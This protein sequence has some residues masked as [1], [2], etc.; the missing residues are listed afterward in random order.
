MST[1][2]FLETVITF[3]GARKSTVELARRLQDSGYDVLLYDAYGTCQPFLD[4]CKDNSLRVRILYPSRDSH[5]IST[6]N[7]IKQFINRASFLFNSI[8]INK[9]LRHYLLSDKPRYVIVNNSKVLSFLFRKPNEIKVMLFARGWF[10]GKQIRTIDRLLYKLFVDRYVCVS[11][12]TRQAIYG[13]GLA[14]LED[15]Y[16]VH[17]AIETSSVDK[18]KNEN[19]KHN[20]FKILISGGFLP[21][22]GLHL[23]IDIALRLLEEQFNFQIIITGIIYK[24]EVSKTYYE[25]IKK[26][27]EINDL[28]GYINLVIDHNDVKEYFEWCDILVHPS[29]TEGLP[30]VVMEAMSMKKP[31][32]ANAV[33]GVTDYILDGFTGFLTNYNNVE[34]YVDIIKRLSSDPALYDEISNRAFDLIKTS[35]SPQ[36]QIKAIIKALK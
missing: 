17:N 22:K 34:E 23:A 6:T 2:V 7:P 21:T 25:R 1:I 14:S 15:I 30:R 11:E 10:I 35:F 20:P 16:V 29:D 8:R 5:I 36:N 13:A 4:A 27:I 3:G 32:I 19:N 12:A 33:G 18:M 9:T 26:L 28:D 31:V 24:T